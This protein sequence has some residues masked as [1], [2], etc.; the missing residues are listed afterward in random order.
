MLTI[1][2]ITKKLQYF[3]SLHPNAGF[4]TKEKLTTVCP[5]TAPKKLLSTR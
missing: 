2:H 5:D 4:D 1:I 3:F